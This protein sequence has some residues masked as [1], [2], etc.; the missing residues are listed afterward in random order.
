MGATRED[1]SVDTIPNCEE[2]SMVSPELGEDTMSAIT[3]S[4]LA[5]LS[6]DFGFLDE[7]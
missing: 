2:S 1:S 4:A 7:A 6:F 5:S 3:L